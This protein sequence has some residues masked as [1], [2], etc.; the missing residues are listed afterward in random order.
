MAVNAGN[1]DNEQDF[2]LSL[3]YAM[4]IAPRP[5]NVRALVAWQKA[6]GGHWANSAKFNPLNTT[7]EMNGAQSMN[8]VGVK[9]YRSW[10]EG[11]EATVKTLQQS[12]YR[13]VVAALRAGSAEQVS[14]ALVRSP[15][16]T[17]TGFVGVLKT[18][19]QLSKE[20]LAKAMIQGP[21]PDT[22]GSSLKDLVND[23][24]VVGDVVGAAGDVVTA[25]FKVFDDVAEALSDI[26][27]T[28]TDPQTWLRLLKF[29]GGIIVGF[30]AFK[31]LAAA[32][33]PPA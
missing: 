4:D 14:A 24:P 5:E 11:L 16:G 3:L 12:D 22:L 6:E 9:V 31:Q 15:W 8:S 25:P 32:A 7:R 20:A 26:W 10:D 33:G 23:T 19:P 28:L 2:A 29:V 1:I 18:I 27:G 13:G 21:D 30:L 17:K